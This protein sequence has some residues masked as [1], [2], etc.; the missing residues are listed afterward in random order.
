MAVALID[1]QQYGFTLIELLV[2]ISI[3]GVLASVVLVSLG[4]ARERGED[5]ATKATFKE[6]QKALELFQIDNGSYP[7]SDGWIQ[8]SAPG[9]LHNDL[10]PTYISSIDLPAITHQYWRGDHSSM[11]TQ[12]GAQFYCFFLE[13]NNPTADD[14]STFTN[15]RF[16]HSNV[17][18][19][20][21]FAI[22]N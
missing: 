8:V 22:C 15:A 18:W 10:V 2:V 3:I 5:A 20:Q 13:L 16:T 17:N 1:R 6:I 11:D 9:P 19:P 4:G 21:D 12:P 14:L 7:T